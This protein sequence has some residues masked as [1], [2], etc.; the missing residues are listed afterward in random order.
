MILIKQECLCNKHGS[1]R[2]D[3]D[4]DTGKCECKPDVSGLKCNECPAG[5]HLTSEGCISSNET[6]HRA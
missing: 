4:Q 5:T 6:F 2:E 1:L 3:C